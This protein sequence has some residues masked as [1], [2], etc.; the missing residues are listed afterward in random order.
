MPLNQQPAPIPAISDARFGLHRAGDFVTCTG[1]DGRD[2][3]ADIIEAALWYFRD[4]VIAL[5]RAGLPV[6]TFTPGVTAQE[7]AARWARSHPVGAPIDYPPLIWVAAPEVVRGVCLASDGS[8]IATR[9]G[10]WAFVVVPKIALN[11]SYY[12]EASIAFLAKRP[13]TLRGRRDNGR[14]TA[15]TIWPEDFRLD[16]AAPLR[17]I[18]ATPLAVRS[19]VREEPRGGAQSAFAAMIPFSLNESSV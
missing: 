5:P 12:N 6:A 3:N 2:C 11:R 19:L 13:L 7:D 15:R 10:D 9:T 1:A 18:A 16:M 4:E 8:V 14:F 17:P